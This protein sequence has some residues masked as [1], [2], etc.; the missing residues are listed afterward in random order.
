MQTA[1]EKNNILWDHLH[2]Q[3]TKKFIMQVLVIHITT[4]MCMGTGWTKQIFLK[5]KYGYKGT[6]VH[7]MGIWIHIVYEMKIDLLELQKMAQSLITIT[8]IEMIE[9]YVLD[10]LYFLIQKKRIK[11]T[12]RD[13]RRWS[14]SSILV[15]E[16]FLIKIDYWGL[17]IILT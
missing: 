11:C 1:S 17:A 12:I 3:F 2:Y 8:S 9:I 16:N 10:E 13:S 5:I 6:F 15:P 7:W 4:P 14:F